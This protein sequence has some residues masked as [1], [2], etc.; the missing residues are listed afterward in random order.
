MTKT[1][2]KGF[3]LLELLIV[4]AILAVLATVAVLVINPVEYLRQARDSQ[5]IGDLGAVKGAIDL[6]LTTATSTD[7]TVGVTGNA[8]RCMVGVA[9]PFAMN[10]GVCVQ[11]TTRLTD[12]TGWVLVN[13][14]LTTAG[15]PLTTLPVDPTNSATYFYA[16]AANETANTYELNAKLESAK[17]MTDQ[18]ID[19]TDGGNQAA[20]YEIGNEPGLDL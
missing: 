3:T 7:L 5:R 10:A 11:N 14:G 6:Y 9:S 2:Q 1:Q 13:L 19:G 16:Y 12:G 18:D 8:A 20:W 17:F 4:I 15:S